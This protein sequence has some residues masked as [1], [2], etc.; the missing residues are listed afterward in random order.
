MHW[1]ENGYYNN[2]TRS[3][4]FSSSIFPIIFSRFSY[5]NIPLKNI[6]STSTKSLIIS[7][8][9]LNMIKPVF[10]IQIYVE[11]LQNIYCLLMIIHVSDFRFLKQHANTLVYIRNGLFQKFSVPPMLRI[12]IFVLRTPSDFRSIFAWPLRNSDILDWVY[13][14]EIQ[15]SQWKTNPLEIQYP[16]YDSMGKIPTHRISAYIL[17]IPLGFPV[18]FKNLRMSPQGY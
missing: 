16:Q 18:T 12:S 13:P 2:S 3:W 14:L 10:G 5:K 9:S 8:L 15:L 4:F 11:M 7:E 1:F 6:V 17:L